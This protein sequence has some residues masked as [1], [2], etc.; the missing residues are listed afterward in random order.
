MSELSDTYVRALSTNLDDVTD[1]D[2]APWGT[3]RTPRLAY[4][5]ASRS[6]SRASVS[7]FVTNMPTGCLFI[8]CAECGMGKTTLLLRVVSARAEEGCAVRYEDFA[9]LTPEEATCRLADLV[10]WS[11]KAPSSEHASFFACDNMPAC[12]EADVE[13]QVAMLRK[14]VRSGCS[15]M[16]SMLPEAEGLASRMGEAECFWS[17]DLRLG[18]P[19]PGPERELFDAYTHGIPALDDG[20]RKV[21]ELTPTNIMAE[22]SYLEPYVCLTAGLL[23]AGIIVE[24]QR[25]RAAMLLM[26]RGT[27]AELKDV[28]GDVDASLWRQLARDVPFLGVE[29]ADQTFCVVGSHAVDGLNASYHVLCPVL[30]PWP[31]LVS[32]TTRLLATRGDLARAAVASLMCSDAVERTALGL[33]WGPEFINAG[34]GSVATDALNEAQQEGRLGLPGLFETECVLRVLSTARWDEA[35]AMRSELHVSTRL[36]RQASLALWCRGLLRGEGLEEEAC[37]PIEGEDSLTDGLTLHGQALSLMLRCRLDEAY[38][39]LINAPIRRTCTTVASVLVDMDYM[40]CTLL[41]GIGPSDDDL[42]EWEEGRVCLDRMGLT[43]LLGLHD[44]IVPLGWLLG[45]RRTARDVYEAHVQRAQR[46]GDTL[47]HGLFLLVSGI[48][49][50]RAGTYMRAHVRIS[51]AGTALD[52]AGAASL[53]QMAQILD[54]AT[55]SH[56]GERIRKTE[57][58]ACKGEGAAFNN[59][60]TVAAAALSANR[61]RRPVATGKWSSLGC[62][63]DMHWLVNILSHDCGV[64]SRRFRDVLPSAWRDSVLRGVSDVDAS[65]GRAEISVSD[66]SVVSVPRVEEKPKVSDGQMAASVEVCLLGGFE[67]RV[68]GIQVPSGHLER[69]RAKSLVAL[70]AAVPGHVAKRYVIMESIWP[71]YDYDTANKCLYSATSVLRTEMLAALGVSENL[72][73]VTANKAERTVSLNADYVGCDV[74]RFE[75]SA[76]RLLD[77]EGED[78]MVVTL[79]REVED[80]YK[81]DLFIP[82]T[83]GLGVVESRSRQLRDLYADALIAGSTAATR[84]GMKTLACRFAYKAHEADALREDAMRVLVVALCAVGRHVEAERSYE[85]YVAHVVDITRRPP[86]RRLRELVSGLL[87]GATRSTGA[88]REDSRVT[89]KSPKVELAP[90][91]ADGPH[92]QM[93]LDLGD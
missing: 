18:R 19:E 65:L 33:A 75:S 30:A 58:T 63:R 10:E 64:F 51:Q 29:V 55:L 88:G 90:E 82:P 26:G 62:P 3:P 78:R 7:H 16:L 48:S 72:P 11:S 9:G 74:D 43:A 66:I 2:G 38:A 22:P 60:V 76:H 41:M 27:L 6:R 67:V 32:A 59:V 35:D 84:L 17:C 39:L 61:D 44:V 31:E 13:R 52:R 54:L 8:V 20:L 42:M 57:M 92:G 93:S 86:S 83:D 87:E 34:E 45:G 15:V 4:A 80:L 77:A 37:I 56:L 49:D 73:L 79:C 53:A 50:L 12:D 14:V 5:R 71:T 69:R 89:P 23:R 70:L 25:L 24:E 47:L 68:N 91:G 81:G 28:L 1:A 21:V 36:G 85:T 46:S 40:L